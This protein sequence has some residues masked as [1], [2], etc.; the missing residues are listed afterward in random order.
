MLVGVCDFPGSYAFPPAGYGG[1]ERWLW[2]V[3][4]GARAAGADVHLLGPG[5]LPELEPDWI[6]KP[7]RLE[8]VIP[9]SLAER[10]LK[11]AGYDLLVVGHEYPSLPAWVRTRSEL[12]C[13]V[14][15]FQHSPSFQHTETAFDGQ[16][17]RLYCY[18]PEMIE[19]YATHQPIAE[20]AV[21]LGLDEEV[22][23]ATRGRDLVWLGRIDEDKAPHLAARAAQLLGRRIRIVGPV[24]SKD[25]VR[26]HEKILTADHVEWVGELGGPAKTAAIRNASVF[27]YT[28]ARRYVEAGAAVFGESVRAGTPMAALTWREGTCAQAALCERTGVTA[29]VPPEADDETASQALAEAIQRAARL[30]HAEVQE[31]GKRRFDPTR[32]FEA[33]AAC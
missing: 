21:H 25:Y 23:P 19:R 17:S 3:A 29:V 28:Y 7:I 32:H 8:D 11:A 4:V 24:F 20:L 27:V 33:L 12:G 15:T 14:A 13:D 2:A 26:S 30:D 6:R 1:I 10:E 16:R 5:W 18:S 31:I 22:P 9:G